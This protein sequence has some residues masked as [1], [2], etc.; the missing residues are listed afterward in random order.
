MFKRSSPYR[1]SV[2]GSGKF[3]LALLAVGQ[4]WPVDQNDAFD[5]ACMDR[6]IIRLETNLFPGD[7]IAGQWDVAG[8]R[9]Q[10]IDGITQ[11]FKTALFIGVE[12]KR[13]SI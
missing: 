9:I 4:C 8:W 12:N 13:W 5:M 1:I 6:R 10:S 7:D 2:I 11:P 3:P